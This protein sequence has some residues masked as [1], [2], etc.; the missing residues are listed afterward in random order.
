MSIRGIYIVLCLLC[1]GGSIITYGQNADGKNTMS[2]KYEYTD[3]WDSI[4]PVVYTNV[5]DNPKYPGGL[6]ALN[7][8]M[9]KNF[10]YPIEAWT[11]TVYKAPP[12]IVYCVVRKDGVA[13]PVDSIMPNLHP[14]YKQE[15]HRV[16]RGMRRWE[17]A[18]IAGQPVDV[19]FN[20]FMLF[21][22]KD[23]IPAYM[24]DY[25]EKTV[26]FAEKLSDN[27]PEAIE[28]AE[29]DTAINRLTPVFS[30]WRG[31]YIP[32][33]FVTLAS[34]H[35]AKGE[36]TD[37][38][39]VLE[40]G[41]EKYHGKG[42]TDKTETT[43]VML[44]KSMDGGYFDLDYYD[45]RKELYAAIQRAVCLDLDG[46]AVEADS[47]YTHA[48]WLADVFIIENG[49]SPND[50]D[51][52]DWRSI[53]DMMQEQAAIVSYSRSSGIQLNPDERFDIEREQ[54]LRPRVDRINEKVDEG[55]ISNARVVQ[56]RNIISGMLNEKQKKDFE[57]NERKF[58]PVKSLI[59]RLRDGSEAETAYLES[60]INDP[61][62]DGKLRSTL[63]KILTDA[64]AL[65]KYTREELMR[66]LTEYAP[67]NNPARS[68]SE[69]RKAAAEFNNCRDALR[70]VYP[71]EWL[72]Y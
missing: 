40:K 12:N 56:I 50:L 69:N 33:V 51:D 1:G 34:M 67:L 45:P 57:R 13:V 7:I 43:E 54:M 46:R 18:M 59:I 25:V 24:E 68:D 55:K 53:A 41:L 61:G 36:Y 52:A 11:D 64:D 27:P 20:L 35:A 60:F 23:G 14:L 32:E 10:V 22:G 26:N 5:D 4:P 71:L 38:A 62:T 29:A 30:V 42:F 49:L 28:A 72:W 17:P 16:F 15:L 3:Y 37:A 65:D 8:Y 2:V 21:S 44:R 6:D 63:Q 31:Y 66:C 47:A 39:D 48:L 9:R 58:E 19:M 70:N